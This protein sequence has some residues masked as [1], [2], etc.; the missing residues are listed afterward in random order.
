[1]FLMKS[2]IVALLTLFV[3]CGIARAQDQQAESLSDADAE[4]LAADVGSADAQVQKDALTRMEQLI[5]SS[6]IAMKDH[7]IKKWAS[8]LSSA[9][10]FHQL[11]LWTQVIINA[12]PYETAS[13]ES[14]QR[15]RARALLDQGGWERALFAA[16]GLYNVARLDHMDGAIASMTQCLKSASTAGSRR[17]DPGIVERFKQEQQQGAQATTRPA[18]GPSADA[19]P[20]SAPSD[21]TTAST[22]PTSVLASIRYIGQFNVFGNGMKKMMGNDYQSL[23]GRGN[24]LLLADQTKQARKVFKHALEVAD[25]EHRAEAAENLARVIKAE[26]GAVG[27]AKAW[28]EKWRHDEEKQSAEAPAAR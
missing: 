28:L 14:L 5:R 12:V 17:S 22:Q 11:G 21:D 19:T 13:V 2:G 15:F 24:L 25:D 16:K 20:S 26:D 27:P 8:A 7:M 6:P 10:Q 1:M 23:L 18:T 3:M 4:K 9:H